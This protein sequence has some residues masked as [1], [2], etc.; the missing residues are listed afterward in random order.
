MN[1]GLSLVVE[2][3][4]ILGLPQQRGGGVI[5]FCVQESVTYTNVTYFII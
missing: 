2:K 5:Y 1:F 3:M 4:D